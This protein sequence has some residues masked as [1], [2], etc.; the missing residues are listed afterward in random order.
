MT[1]KSIIA[2]LNLEFQMRDDTLLI[3]GITSS[4]A[5]LTLNLVLEAEFTS[6]NHRAA[7]SPYKINCGYCIMKCS[8]KPK[9]VTY[10]LTIP[11]F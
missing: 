7:I 8:L 6:E 5:I 9:Q 11:Y 4:H 2:V 10:K 1:C 3:I